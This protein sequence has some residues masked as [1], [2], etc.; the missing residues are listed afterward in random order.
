MR[1]KRINFFANPRKPEAVNGLQQ[2]IHIA[3]HHGYECGVDERIVGHVTDCAA[4]EERSEPPELLV[5]LGGDGTILMAASLTVEKRVPI[6]GIN[7]GRIGFLSE[8]ALPAFDE[9]L[10]RI[11]NGDYALEERMLLKCSINGEREYL[12]LNDALIGKSTS[13]GV[14]GVNV[15]IDGV[16]AGTV[17]GD[18][19]VVSTPTGSTAYSMSAGGPVI[20]PGL[21]AILVTPICPHS[22]S[23]RP[24]V[25][26]ETSVLRLT[27]S[28]EACLALDGANT[29]VT[30]LPSD[31]IE[32]SKARE[33]AQ[34]IRFDPK[35]FYSLIREKLS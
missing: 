10:T 5:A 31:V 7:F 34:F 4:C 24:I 19:L 28:S 26:S 15:A 35:N 16:D 9:A 17:F 27:V 12:C 18:G 8:I 14:I 1:V 22:F 20:A 2:A 25:A 32:L 33:A 21:N 30:V 11:E 6:L 3:K 13:L 29:T 23:F